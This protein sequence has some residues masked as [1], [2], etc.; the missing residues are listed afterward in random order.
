MVDR[1]SLVSSSN[2]RPKKSRC[3]TRRKMNLMMVVGTKTMSDDSTPTT[4]RV[5]IDSTDSASLSAPNW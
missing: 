2:V 1:S 4:S 5:A 3:L